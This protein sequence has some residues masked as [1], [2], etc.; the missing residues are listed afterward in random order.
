MKYQCVV[1]EKVYDGD[2]G[3]PIRCCDK[4]LRHEFEEENG[5]KEVWNYVNKND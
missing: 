1:C 4:I 2:K 3:M 5:D